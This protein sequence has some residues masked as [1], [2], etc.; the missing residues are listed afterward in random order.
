MREQFD[1]RDVGTERAPHAGELHA[2]DATAEDDGRGRNPVE[3]Q[4][5]IAGDDPLAVDLQARKG[6][7]L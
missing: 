3:R 5:V 2:D 1:D 6:A 4:C 7:S